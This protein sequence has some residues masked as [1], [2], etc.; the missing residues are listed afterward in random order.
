MQDWR[1]NSPLL[2][3]N[4]HRVKTY[5]AFDFFVQ[6]TATSNLISDEVK[7]AA[8]GSMGNN[9]KVPVLKYNGDVQV[10]NSRTCV[11]ADR[12]N[13][14]ALYS[15]VWKNY[16][17][18]FTMVEAFYRNNNISYTRDF[19]AKMNDTVNA[20]MDAID[21]D[22]VLALEVHKTQVLE[23][24]L[25]YSFVGNEVRAKYEERTDIFGDVDIMQQENDYNRV[26]HIIANGST[27]SIIEKLA[28]HGFYNDVNYT[29]EYSDKLF[30]FTKNVVNEAGD[31]ATFFVVEDGNVSLLSRV[32]RQE[33]LGGKSG[34]HEFGTVTLPLMEGVPVGY[35]YYTDVVDE[36]KFAA[37]DPAAPAHEATAD[38]TC[39][40]KEFYGLSVDI[41]YIVAYN[42]DESTIAN[43]I[44]KAS[45]ENGE[46]RN[47]RPVVIVNSASN[48]VYTAPVGIS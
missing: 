35:H 8:L 25:N 10:S 46:H 7:N 29:A 38:L 17:I 48:P 22:A 23:N 36:S 42:S 41:A 9:I 1:I 33:F 13:E 30:H 14:S 21:K 45:I 2:D 32:S 34:E 16:S 19:N 18:G 12:H 4:M 31:Y 39:V 6:Q 28:G 47:A 40:I 20:L 3:K 26:N 27:K 44:I 37:N 11:I 24:A 5:G 43:P 15:V